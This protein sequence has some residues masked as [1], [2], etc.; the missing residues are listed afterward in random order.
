MLR[1]V[2][3]LCSSSGVQTR[4]TLPEKMELQIVSE[5]MIKPLTS[6][7]PELR[8]VP[9]CL[10][11]LHAP[12]IYLPMLYFF[13]NSNNVGSGHHRLLKDSLSKALTFYYP[14][15]GTLHL[16]PASKHLS[17]P[18][19][20]LQLFLSKTLLLSVHSSFTHPNTQ[21]TLLTL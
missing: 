11:D 21:I 10:F 14:F 7:P 1:A 5:E 15:A 12:N 2:L 9:L 16:T 6:T 8:Y 17:H 18:G 4:P 20:F 13:N 3:K 19:Q